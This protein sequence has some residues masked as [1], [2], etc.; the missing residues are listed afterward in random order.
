MRCFVGVFLN[1]L[2]SLGGL[3]EAG[4]GGGQMGRGVPLE[5]S[6]DDSEM[7]SFARHILTSRSTERS[8][9]SEQSSWLQRWPVSI[10]KRRSR[11]R[12]ECTIGDKNFRTR[13]TKH[14][15]PGSEGMASVVK[16]ILRGHATCRGSTDSASPNRFRT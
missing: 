7:H 1:W 11:R 16:R 2:R 9:L 6:P 12:Y 14:Q 10:C 4:D 3:G 13:S 8:R 5:R 15:R